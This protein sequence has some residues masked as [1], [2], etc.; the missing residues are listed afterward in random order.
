MTIAAPQMGVNWIGLFFLGA[1][2]RF[3]VHDLRYHF[4]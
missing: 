1:V 4:V 3:I 2:M